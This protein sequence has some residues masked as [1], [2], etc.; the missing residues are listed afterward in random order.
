MLK[1]QDSNRIKI[2]IIVILLLANVIVFFNDK[3]TFRQIDFTSRITSS[4]EFENKY[5]GNQFYVYEPKKIGTLEL[6]VIT[7]YAPSVYK[8][9]LLAKKNGKLHFE[10]GINDDASIQGNGITFEIY[11]QPKE[12]T[13][14]LLFS[15][16]LLP[17][18]KISDNKIYSG[19][20]DLSKF[21][22]RNITLL[23]VT[24][25]NGN[26]A[27]DQ[28]FWANV[29]YSFLSPV[30]T[31]VGLLISLLLVFII[32]YY[33]KVRKFWQKNNVT[34]FS[35][36]LIVFGFLYLYFITQGTYGFHEYRQGTYYSWLSSQFDQGKLGS[37]AAPNEHGNDFS[38][39]NG[40]K[41]LYFGP[42]PAVLHLLYLKVFDGIIYG[43]ILTHIFSL[44]NLLFFWLILIKIRNKYFDQSSLFGVILF[45]IAYACGPLMF[46]VS[47]SFVYEES[48]IIGS[49]FLLMGVFA[50]LSAYFKNNLNYRVLLTAGFFFALAFLC[51]YTLILY[52]AIPFI[53]LFSEVQ[54]RNRK[55]WQ[56]F[57]KKSLCLI[58]PI[59]IGI[60]LIFLYNHLRFNNV[61]EFGV[62][63]VENSNIEDGSR[64]DKKLANDLQYIPYNLY[65]YF[66]ALPSIQKDSHTLVDTVGS[67]P[68]LTGKEFT[69]SIFLNSPLLLFGLYLGFKVWRKK[70][71]IPAKLGKI[72]LAILLGSIITIG[73]LLAFLGSTRRYIQDFLPLLLV[74]AYIG[75]EKFFGITKRKYILY[76]FLVIIIIYTFL[77]NS[78]V[79]CNF[80]FR[81]DM[82]KCFNIYNK[83]YILLN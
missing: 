48:I 16:T 59:L 50:L 29:D 63:Y 38:Y 72:L 60:I 13:K 17:V 42:L 49:T 57:A 18:E 24:G 56:E 70:E 9:D 3:G 47:R 34:I 5:W 26:N 33:E 40:K 10:Y 8:L 30:L 61:L 1:K 73:Y 35:I 66:I 78:A 43:S 31:R 2:I 71:F 21:K 74:I 20:T 39:Y 67:F 75:M 55:S 45:F 19:E 52:L 28:G 68:K 7:A 69:T 44:V 14:Q 23:F 4:K 51:R 82:N 12:D 15:N 76:F 46:C 58:S 27:Y 36:L 79:T 54:M 25:D 11:I 37:Y 83:D 65:N 64:I 80:A 6:N 32:I 41:F 81:G 22:D 77:I 62:S 53:L